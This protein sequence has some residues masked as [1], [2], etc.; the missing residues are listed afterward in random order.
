MV[1]CWTGPVAP[2]ADPPIAHPIHPAPGLEVRLEGAPLE[3]TMATRQD[4]KLKFV[5]RNRGEVVV[6]PKIHQSDLTI[7]GES[8]V[9]WGA[10]VGNGAA[11][12]E[13]EALPPQHVASREWKFG[14][15]L[16][17]APGDYTLVL[18]VSDLESA[19]VRVH[20]AP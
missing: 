15:H 10:A 2:V 19:P 17:L 11:D 20:V 14:T 16:F 1:G 18:H 3:L 6:D 9:Q 4:F 7:N 13:W 5:V 8:S 12:A